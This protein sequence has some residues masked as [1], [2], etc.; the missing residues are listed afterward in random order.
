MEWPA[1]NCCWDKKIRKCFKSLNQ[2]KG[3]LIQAFVTAGQRVL[4]DRLRSVLFEDVESW[5]N[6]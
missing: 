3:N 5:S 1:T 6:I 2:W 4:T